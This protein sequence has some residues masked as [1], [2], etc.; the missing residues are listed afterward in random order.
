MANFTDIHE[1]LTPQLKAIITA[2]TTLKNSSRFKKLLEVNL[3]SHLVPFPSR[4]SPFQIVLAFG[5]Y[6]N[7][8]KR[9]PAYGFKLASLEIV[10]AK[11]SSFDHHLFFLFHS[12]L[13]HERMINV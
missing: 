12:Y 3:I 8:S 1:T 10:R 9:G 2:S 13:I 11:L 4:V 7:S 6:M 5:N